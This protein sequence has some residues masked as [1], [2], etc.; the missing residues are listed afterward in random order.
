MSFAQVRPLSSMAAAD[1]WGRTVAASGPIATMRIPHTRRL[2][3]TRNQ[4]S[5]EK[6]TR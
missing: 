5:G 6:A 1:G 3:V 4:A 2:A